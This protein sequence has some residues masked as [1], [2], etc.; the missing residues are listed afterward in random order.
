MATCVLGLAWLTGCSSPPPHAD[1]GHAN[2][3]LGRVEETP[4]VSV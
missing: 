2:A 3:E 1:V 4:A